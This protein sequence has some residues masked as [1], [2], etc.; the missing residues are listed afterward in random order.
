MVSDAHRRRLAALEQKAEPSNVPD[1]EI[2]AKQAAV[3]RIFEIIWAWQKEVNDALP[4]LHKDARNWRNGPPDLF[5]R[6]TPEDQKVF[7]VILDFDKT[8]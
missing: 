4:P 5:E 7:Q 2:A 8:I 1:P 6:M 3:G